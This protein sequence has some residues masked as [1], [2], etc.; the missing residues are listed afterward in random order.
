[1]R[2]GKQTI[3]FSN[4]PVIICTSSVVGKKEGEGPLK[5]EFD[6]ILTDDKF[7]AISWEAAES[8][9][10][11][12]AVTSALKKANLSNTQINYVLAGDLMNQ[13]AASHYGI[14]DLNIPFIGMYGACST[15]TESL[16]V[17]AMITEGGFADKLAC[18]TSSHF[19]SAEK[20]FRNPLEY[21]GQRTPAAQW[22]V[23][24]GGCAIM[25]PDG[26]GPRITY[27]TMGK[28]IDM[29]ITDLS[30][31]GAAMAP[32]AIDT[33]TSFFDD[34]GLKPQDF[35]GIF[36]G[37]LGKIGSD[38]LKEKIK[39]NGY[40]IDSVHNDCGLLIYDLEKQ[41]VHSGG[42]GCGCMASVLCGYIMNEIKKGK[43]KKV[44]CMAT[45]ALMNTS[46]VLQ[47]ETIPAVAHAIV[48]EA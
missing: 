25:S 33:L 37:D 38:I 6:C 23:T 46:V 11:H 34:T 45:G 32:A 2:I 16:A 5:S 47:G 1:M 12:L 18:V 26:N 44:I 9:I 31:M 14:R 4:S 24:G 8:K 17:G 15:M 29:G 20:Q 22:T 48:I 43:L 42:S 41:D 21:G 36:T 28:I 40:D 3:K 13:C 10:Q 27:A 7:N 39:E 30:N 35:D 19:C